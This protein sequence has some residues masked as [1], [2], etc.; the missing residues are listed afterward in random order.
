M[1]PVSQVDF[2]GGMSSLFDSTKAPINQYRIGLNVRIRK[3]AIQGAF[4]PVKHYSISGNHQGIF[5]VDDKL[6]LVVNGICQRL[7][8]QRSFSPMQM[9]YSLDPDVE[10]IYHQS[11]PT[12]TNFFVGETFAPSDI[13]VGEPYSSVISTFNEGVVLQDGINQPVLLHATLAN[14]R[15]R[16][17]K[18]WS[19]EQPE[20]VPVGKQMTSSGNKLF[21][22]SSDG[23][24]IY[25]SVSG[26]QLDFVLNINPTTGAAR[27]DAATTNLAV[28]AAKTVAL[29]PAQSG[30]ILTF[31]KYKTYELYPVPEIQKYFG[32]IYLHPRDVF[33]VGAVNHLAFTYINGDSV[34]V[35]PQGIQEFN[36]V[37]QTQR[38][39][40]NN[41][42][43]API[44]DY[45]IRPITTTA[46]ATVND[47]TLFAV[48]TVYGDGILVYD[49][50]IQAFVS[51]DLVGKVKE[52]AVFEDQG[53]PRCFFITYAG[54]VYEMPLY[55]GDRSK[56]YIYFGDLN[57]GSAQELL[58]PTQVHLQFT[59]VRAAGDVTLET[60]VDHKV[61]VRQQKTLAS[62]RPSENLLEQSPRSI[63][64]QGET[65]MLPLSFDVT[66][67]V[68]G[69][70]VGQLVACAADARLVSITHE[71]DSSLISTT[72]PVKATTLAERISVV[73]N[74]RADTTVYNVTSAT[75][76]V[77][78]TYAAFALNSAITVYDGDRKYT[79]KFAG[80]AVVFVASNSRVEL[81]A[82]AY[83]LDYSTFA[84]VMTNMAGTKAVIVPG[85][86][87]FFEQFY[88][89]KALFTQRQLRLKPVCGASDMDTTNGLPFFAT[90]QV[91]EYY[92]Y[93]TE[94]VNFFCISFKIN[95]AQ[96][97][98]DADGE[99]A[100]TPT[101]MLETGYIANWVKSITET[102][103]NKFNVVVFPFLPY[104]S[105]IYS[106]GYK[107]LR[108]PFKLW[109]IHAVLSGRDPNYQRFYDDGVYYLNVGTGNAGSLSGE[110]GLLLS[111]NLDFYATSNLLQGEFHD[112]T[113][114]V[115]DRFTITR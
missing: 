35:S 103:T 15:L 98:I 82:N 36:Q 100:S 5:A 24:S 47:Y 13:N 110:S 54:E 83:L 101:S 96:S 12:P 39:S 9:L 8:D 40:N 78:N 61:R 10:Y 76:T 89:I 115:R 75:V 91:P 114:T 59:N 102:Q 2:S 84:S 79:T 1:K 48:Q 64:L 58:K 63:P 32:E 93:S 3:N 73:G 68:A 50:Q 53:L 31:T 29:Q 80:D 92:L 42:L 51:F 66:K 94:H 28:S 41:P 90:L 25:Q 99:L 111:G 113:D 27:G 16:T 106:P 18:Q 30:G 86:V 34:F 4:K 37:L 108:W 69:Y 6:V 7:V 45:L 97:A 14:R 21:I 70:G 109:G 74:I 46:T 22:V 55:T 43:G 49:A 60:Y 56:F 62:D 20:Y 104:S 72:V 26:R 23:K 71:L 57:S 38:V 112:S 87:G 11:V 17:Y 52:F 19:F 44:V 107:T 85:A 33:P 95:T 88:H 81:P 77:G 67:G 65:E 105:G